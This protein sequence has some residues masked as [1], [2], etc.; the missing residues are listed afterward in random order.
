MNSSLVCLLWTPVCWAPW[1]GCEHLPHAHGSLICR[2]GLEESLRPWDHFFADLNLALPKSS[3]L[4]EVGE[5]QDGQLRE[6]LWHV[7]RYCRYSSPSVK[8]KEDENISWIRLFSFVSGMDFDR[9]SWEKNKLCIMVFLCSSFGW[10][11]VR[12]PWGKPFPGQ[13][14]DA[15]ATDAPHTD[16]ADVTKA[17]SAAKSC[18]LAGD[19]ARSSWEIRSWPEGGVT[20]AQLGP[21]WPNFQ[22]AQD[23]TSF[24]PESNSLELFLLFLVV[25]CYCHCHWSH[26][27]HT[28]LK[29]ICVSLKE[30]HPCPQV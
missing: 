8:S 3:T 22:R 7:V 25:I 12:K 1:W 14:W 23:E 15:D 17:W 30:R 28:S 18:G 11:Q 6:P 9:S 24:Q 27:S 10:C 26:V 21:T 20:L 13:V 5:I 16:A 4:Q 19:A 2:R 29:E